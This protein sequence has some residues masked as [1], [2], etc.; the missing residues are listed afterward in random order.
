MLRFECSL[1]SSHEM[2][3]YFVWW[4]EVAAPGYVVSFWGGWL[5]ANLGTNWF[6]SEN[7]TA[8]APTT[9]SFEHQIQANLHISCMVTWCTCGS[10]QFWYWWFVWK[11]ALGPTER[12]TRCFSSSSDDLVLASLSLSWIRSLSKECL[13]K[14]RE[15][16]THI[17]LSLSLVSMI[18]GETDP[19]FPPPTG[20]VKETR[21]RRGRWTF[22]PP[23]HPL[24]IDRF[25]HVVRLEELVSEVSSSRQIGFPQFD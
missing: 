1:W 21:T 18:R 13:S 20:R 4:L 2:Q 3:S 7:E 5:C 10:H 12:T 9:P 25:P 8:L 22:P 19:S 14:E 16:N 24:T 23:S 6:L 15:S 11:L 17:D